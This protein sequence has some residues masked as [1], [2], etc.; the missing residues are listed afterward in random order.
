MEHT[1][2]H[3][4]SRIDPPEWRLHSGSVYGF[5][6]AEQGAIQAIVQKMAKV[7]SGLPG[8]AYPPHAGLRS[9][10]RRALQND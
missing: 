2:H 6:Y 10:A 4:A 5:R 8:G 3:L 1:I 7:V 9:G